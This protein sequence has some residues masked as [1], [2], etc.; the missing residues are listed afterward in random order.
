MER[1]APEVGPDHFPH[2]TVMIGTAS[3]IRERLCILGPFIGTRMDDPILTLTLAIFAGP[4]RAGQA[5][6]P[7]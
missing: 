6:E 7:P 2:I 1:D 3:L 5:L 4:L